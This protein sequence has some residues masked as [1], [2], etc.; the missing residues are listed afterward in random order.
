MGVLFSYGCPFLLEIYGCPFLSRPFLS[1]LKPFWERGEPFRQVLIYQTIG[2]RC[3]F[4][5]AF[6]IQD[7]T[8]ALF[9]LELGKK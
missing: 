3:F 8:T 5:K 6:K 1:R 7:L 9:F 4:L 2:V